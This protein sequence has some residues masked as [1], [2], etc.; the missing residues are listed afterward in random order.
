M[1]KYRIEIM[2][3]QIGYLG[4]LHIE[5]KNSIEAKAKAIQELRLDIFEQVENPKMKLGEMRN[6]N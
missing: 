1:A 4:T 2:T 3:E 6:E 5:A